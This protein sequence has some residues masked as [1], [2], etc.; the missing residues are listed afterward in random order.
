MQKQKVLAIVGATASGKTALGVEL[1]KKFNG[2][3][4]SA[5]SMQIYE[6]LDITTAKPTQEEMQNIKHYLIGFQPRTENFSVADYVNL[7]SEKIQEI[8]S[9]KKLPILVGG[10]G[11][12]LNCLLNGMQFAPEGNNQIREK[13]IQRLETEGIENLYQELQALDLEATKKIHKNNHV[14]VI[15]ALEVCLATGKT[16]TE[17]KAKNMAHDSPYDAFW[18]GL[19]YEN[20]QDLYD[21]INQRVYRMLESGMLQE[22]K[23][24]YQQ[25]TVGTASMAIGYKEL[26]PYLEN[27]ACLDDCIAMIQQETRR[28]AKRQLTWF[29]RN[30]QIHWLILSKNDEL[31]KISKKAEKMIAKNENM[32]YNV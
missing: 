21:K 17:Y 7:A 20:R 2:E 16:F 10:T 8:A 28:Y 30:A 13:L 14:R 19:D 27:K 12:Y 23:Q 18:L 15:R 29:R 32:W 4:I 9:R 1:A 5:D 25:G 31:Q 24:A 6:G 11:L 22:V 26:I 3:I